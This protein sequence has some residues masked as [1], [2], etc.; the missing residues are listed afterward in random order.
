MK[1]T[2]FALTALLL[3]LAS[4]QNAT[5]PAKPCT[6]QLVSDSVGPVCVPKNPKRIVTIQW[7]DSENILALGV[8]PV[9]M[10]DI[11]GFGE[12]VQAPMPIAA[13]VKDV[14]TRG[15]F[16]LETVA[17]LKPDLI[18]NSSRSAGREALSKIAPT[19][20]FNP[21]SSATSG[22][23]AYQ[24]MRD[25]FTLLGQV[26]GRQAQARAV[27]AQL[28]AAQ[29]QALRTLQASGRGGETFVLSQAYGGKE[30]AM[31][32]F[33]AGSMGVQILEKIGLR[34]AWKPGKTPDYGFDT[35]SLEGLTTLETQNFFG[36]T[37]EDDNVYVAPSNRAVWNNLSFVKAGHGYSLPSN[38]WL[39]GGPKSAQ[40]LITNVVKVMTQKQ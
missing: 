27:L 39:F 36:I 12:Y 6:G 34:N 1:K 22:K 13:S 4:A 19:L 29:L 7:D 11:K 15:E 33:G 40:T 2:P 17:A 26:T 9:G 25:H 20:V 3:G 16:S 31:R 28:D 24:L 37:A 18:I 30:P 21:Y 38:T 10:A 23:T 5:T 35:L 14:G 8:Q 32:L